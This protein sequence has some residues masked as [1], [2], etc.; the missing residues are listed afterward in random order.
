MPGLLQAHRGTSSEAAARAIAA[1]SSS[2]QAH[3]GQPDPELLAE[4]GGGSEVGMV[5]V[6]RMDYFGVDPPGSGLTLLVSPVINTE[7]IA[8][9]AMWF[10]HG[11]SAAGRRRHVGLLDSI[12]GSRS[13]GP[14]GLDV[15]PDDAAGAAQ[16]D[17]ALG[18]G[19]CHC[20]FFLPIE[21]TRSSNKPRLCSRC[22]TVVL[23]PWLLFR[24]EALRDVV[25]V[26]HGGLGPAQQM[27]Q[28]QEVLSD[29]RQLGGA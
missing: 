28:V 15:V 3:H 13:A 19:A 18:A 10:S 20:S 16:V 12:A 2:A 6:Y 27:P 14:G 21:V 11:W 26:Q 1:T 22:R 23:L 9:G 4:I 7:A 5:T 8:V 17:S 24:V 29:V 25:L